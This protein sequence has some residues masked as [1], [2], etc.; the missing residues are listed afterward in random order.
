MVQILGKNW[1]IFRYTADFS[2]LASILI[3]ITRIVC[4]RTCHG[5][6]LKTHCLYFLVFIFRYCPAGF[7]S[8]PLYNIVFKIFYICSTALVI[9]LIRVVF[10]RS[11]DSKH[12]T[13]SMLLILAICIPPTL[14]STRD[15]S[16]SE[17]LWTYSLW[18]E[19]VVILPQ[20]FMLRRTQRTDTL[21]KDY[22]FFLGSYRLF[23]VLNWVRKLIKKRKTEY[24]VWI[25]GIIQSLVYC[26]FLYY[27]IK[28][29]LKGTEMEL[30]R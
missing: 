9:I 27:Y 21:T 26:D 19:S 24:V 13:F 23:Y 28:A 22:I 12:D 8:P 30:P 11:Y 16:V 17:V 5:I 20:L 14:I 29:F 1:N 25:T 15:Y 10:R 18:L 3:L 4:G 6:S 7:F 2:H